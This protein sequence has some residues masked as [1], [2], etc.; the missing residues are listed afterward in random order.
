MATE[1]EIERNAM[2]RKKLTALLKE[3]NFDG[4]VLLA[5]SHTDNERIMT[6]YT[7]GV[8]PALVDVIASVVQLIAVTAYDVGKADMKSQLTNTSLTNLDSEKL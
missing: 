6:H 3:V 8:V 7:S 4:F 1:K 2:I 5:Y